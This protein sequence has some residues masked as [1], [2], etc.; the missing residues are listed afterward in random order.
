M[1]DA[2]TL[3]QR[4]VA[5]SLKIGNKEEDPLTPPEIYKY[6][7]AMAEQLRDS[8]IAPE[9]KKDIFKNVLNLS[10]N[11]NSRLEIMNEDTHLLEEID[12]VYN[13][14]VPDKNALDGKKMEQFVSEAIKYSAAIIGY[15]NKIIESMK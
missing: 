10:S 9:T 14:V 11:I 4:L 7:S 13:L 12:Y 6:L 2:P 5:L 1:T 8:N 15:A 3:R